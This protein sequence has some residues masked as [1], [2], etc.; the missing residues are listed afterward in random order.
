MADDVAYSSP[1][2]TITNTFTENGSLSRAAPPA[3]RPHN[4]H[5]RKRALFEMDDRGEDDFV[6]SPE[7]QC[8]ELRLSSR[9]HLIKH[10]KLR[11]K[12][13]SLETTESNLQIFAIDQKAAPFRVDDVRIATEIRAEQHSVSARGAT[14]RF[15]QE[16]QTW[17][18][19]K[20]EQLLGIVHFAEDV[21]M[22]LLDP[23]NVA[24]V[25]VGS[26][27]YLSEFVYAL[28]VEYLRKLNESGAYGEIKGVPQAEQSRPNHE[29][30]N[31]F[32]K[33]Y[34]NWSM[35][36]TLFRTALFFQSSLAIT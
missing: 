13:A 10:N 33:E 2:N 29:M 5:R 16:P 25:G 19:F 1:L 23:R 6:P 14:M 24:L 22:W 26:H 20:L 11:Q 3:P 7:K 8:V 32:C 31:L 35:R 30:Y 36:D 27:K 12:L 9:L 34:E 18:D 4:K 17:S 28:I 15:D 21:A